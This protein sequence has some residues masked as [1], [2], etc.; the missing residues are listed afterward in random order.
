MFLWFS[1]SWNSGH[2]EWNLSPIRVYLGFH[3]DGS[4]PTRAEFLQIFSIISSN[5]HPRNLRF[6]RD[7]S[8][9]WCTPEYSG[10]ILI[11]NF[12]SADVYLSFCS[13][14]FCC[15]FNSGRHSFY[16]SDFPSDIHRGIV[17]LFSS[18]S[19]HQLARDSSWRRRTGERKRNTMYTS[20]NWSNDPESG[21]LGITQISLEHVLL[22]R[23]A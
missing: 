5:Y 17:F 10:N 18:P 6:Q 4:L 19:E 22:V 3:Q 9:S 7:P 12:L 14:F 1:I 23:H 16:Q 20:S 11:R 13:V 2:Y 21:S 15:T 8:W